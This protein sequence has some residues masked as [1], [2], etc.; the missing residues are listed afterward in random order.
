MIDQ[1]ADLTSR[2]SAVLSRFD[3]L[4]NQKRILE[5]EEDELNKQKQTI[6]EE[7]E[8]VNKQLKRLER[9]EELV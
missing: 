7:K 8:K 5:A 6:L 3:E 9:R 1:R 4:E 2:G